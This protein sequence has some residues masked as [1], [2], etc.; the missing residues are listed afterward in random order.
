MLCFYVKFPATKVHKPYVKRVRTETVNLAAAGLSTSQE[1]SSTSILPAAC[2][3]TDAAYEGDKGL[4][5][6]M[7]SPPKNDSVIS[8]HDQEKEKKEEFIAR[9]KQGWTLANVESIK[10]GELYLIVSTNFFSIYCLFFSQLF[11]LF[12]IIFS[13][14]IFY[15]LFLQYL[16]LYICFSIS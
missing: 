5:V 8:S 2:P 12:I 6:L 9:A 1:S 3:I 16:K 11:Y 13:R 4:D 15:V 7:A 10:I 14:N